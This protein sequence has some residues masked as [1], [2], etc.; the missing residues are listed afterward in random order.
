MMSRPK[1]A[2]LAVDDLDMLFIADLPNDLQ[3]HIQVLGHDV[4]LMAGQG[5]TSIDFFDML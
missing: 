2:Q 5:M 4:G 3:V 1:A